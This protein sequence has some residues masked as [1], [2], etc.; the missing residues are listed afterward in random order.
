MKKTVRETFHFMLVMLELRICVESLVN[1]RTLELRPVVQGQCCETGRSYSIPSIRS[2]YWRC[3]R[4]AD[5]KAV[6]YNENDK[7]CRITP[8][9]CAVLTPAQPA[10]DLFRPVVDLGRRMDDCIDWSWYLNP[11][12]LQGTMPERSVGWRD[13][14]LH[15]ARIDRANDKMV[16]LFSIWQA[17]WVPEVYDWSISN[18]LGDIQ[19][20]ELLLVSEGCT[21][22]WISCRV[23]ELP[24]DAVPGGLLDGEPTYIVRTISGL[25]GYYI[26]S[27]P[28]PVSCEAT[29]W[30]ATEF[31]ILVL[32]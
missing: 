22:A 18:W 20:W 24:A 32:L 3:A 26:P 6:C 10:A 19:S 23:G 9:P 11:T 28:L 8:V 4:D 15:V 16:G 30:T 2:C 1:K 21:V 29:A 17:T 5:C 12:A 13:A 25:A 14:L 31:E 7:T 27:E